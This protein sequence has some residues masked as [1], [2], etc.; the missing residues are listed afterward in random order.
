MQILMTNLERVNYFVEDEDISAI[1]YLIDQT[2][3]RLSRQKAFN[4][5]N[6]I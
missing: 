3:F 5:S 1:L 6:K 4:R 2:F